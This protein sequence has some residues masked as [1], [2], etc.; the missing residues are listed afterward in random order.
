MRHRKLYRRGE[1]VFPEGLGKVGHHPRILGLIDEVFVGI[2]SQHDHR[3]ERR[4]FFCHLYAVHTG[5]PDVEYRYVGF[6]PLYEIEGF[7]PVPR[8]AH[9]LVADAF[10]EFLQVDA[11]Q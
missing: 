10:E 4:H 7:L 3:D 5:H 9:H 8:L 1:V 11:D 2:S 6:L